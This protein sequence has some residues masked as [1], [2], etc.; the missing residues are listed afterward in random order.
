MPWT[1][2]LQERQAPVDVPAR[3][4][5]LFSNPDPIG[6]LDDSNSVHH[7]RGRSSNHVFQSL[8]ACHNALLSF[9]PDPF[10]SGRIRSSLTC[11]LL[12]MGPVRQPSLQPRAFCS[13]RSACAHTFRTDSTPRPS[14]RCDVL[15]EA[16]RIMISP[17]LSLCARDQHF[18][19]ASLN[20]KWHRMLGWHNVASIPD[21][22]STG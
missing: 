16:L 4:T 9:K 11:Q 22:D 13:L 14:T 12:F 15:Q 3:T 18:K 17:L 10:L 5:A 6:D 20:P 2:R 8:S 19:W 21:D 1:A 7:R